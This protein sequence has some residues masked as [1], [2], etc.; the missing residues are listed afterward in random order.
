MERSPVQTLTGSRPLVEAWPQ[1]ETWPLDERTFLQSEKDAN[2][3]FFL[4][5]ASPFLSPKGKMYYFFLNFTLY[6]F[7][8]CNIDTLFCN[9]WNISLFPM[10]YSFMA[11][12]NSL[13][14]DAK[15][16]SRIRLASLFVCKTQN[17]SASAALHLLSRQ[18]TDSAT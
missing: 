7:I 16:V 11:E 17:G 3:A 15:P 9:S 13:C 14:R 6:I 1:V 5:L 12:S 8:D 10:K 18:C 2:S 4:R